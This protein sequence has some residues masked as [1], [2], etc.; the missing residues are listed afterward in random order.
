MNDEMLSI[1]IQHT[2]IAPPEEEQPIIESLL[3][4]HCQNIEIK[5][6]G[7]KGNDL[8]YTLQSPEPLD[9][10]IAGSVFATVIHQMIVRTAK[11]KR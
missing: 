7:K 1:K 10:Y 8:Y 9:F 2:C 3:R 5:F 6:D 11:N 4:K